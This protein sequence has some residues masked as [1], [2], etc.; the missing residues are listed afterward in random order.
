MLPDIILLSQV[1]VCQ[2]FLLI[3]GVFLNFANH[4]ILILKFW[5]NRQDLLLQGAIKQGFL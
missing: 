4:K 1:D 3:S 2:V 5:V